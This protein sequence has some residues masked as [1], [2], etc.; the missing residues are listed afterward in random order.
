MGID[1]LNELIKAGNYDLITLKEY[2]D[3]LDNKLKYG[4]SIVK[5]LASV[6]NKAEA[7]ERLL[8][9]VFEKPHI[10]YSVMYEKK[11]VILEV[12][13]ILLKSYIVSSLFSGNK[14]LIP[15]N[16]VLKEITVFH[17]LVSMYNPLVIFYVNVQKPDLFHKV[18]VKPFSSKSIIYSVLPHNTRTI[19]FRDF[20]LSTSLCFEKVFTTLYQDFVFNRFEL[21]KSYCNQIT[22]PVARRIAINSYMQVLG[23]VIELFSLVIR[24]ITHYNELMESISREEREN[25]LYNILNK[26]FTNIR[27]KI[28]SE[29]LSLVKIFEGLTGYSRENV[30]KAIFEAINTLLLDQG[31]DDYTL[32]NALTLY[33]KTTRL[34]NDLKVE[35]EISSSI[36]LGKYILLL[37][38]IL[39]IIEK[40]LV[41]HKEKIH[42]LLHKNV[43]PYITLNKKIKEVIDR[44]Y[45][46]WLEKK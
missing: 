13:G 10:A 35:T 43:E 8:S 1:E 2:L 25:I 24:S 5:R 30:K 37:Q 38:D 21:I 41:V 27:N 33:V 46:E 39:S 23:G 40:S 6:F 29:T 4:T 36:G 31:L 44:G 11:H 9:I 22:N 42:S 7:C 17:P 32:Y 45:L 20:L 34:L 19:L 14:A 26:Y 16:I 12:R 3:I 28:L 15:S 18:I